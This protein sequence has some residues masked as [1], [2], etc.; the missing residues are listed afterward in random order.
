MPDSPSAANALLDSALPSGTS[1]TSPP[2]AKQ[3]KR[4]VPNSDGADENPAKK[5]KVSAV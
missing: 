5:A 2:S 4:S 3:A 1:A